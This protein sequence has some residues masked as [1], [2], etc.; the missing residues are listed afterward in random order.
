MK[1]QKLQ[2][3]CVMYIPM[4][5]LQLMFTVNS[6]GSVRSSVISSNVMLTVGG[7]CTTVFTP[8][9]KIFVVQYWYYSQCC[10]PD[11]HH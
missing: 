3:L 2:F 8:A 9:E 11:L 10:V 6:P 1:Q 4:G 5:W 7:G